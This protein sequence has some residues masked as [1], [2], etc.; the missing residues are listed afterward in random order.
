MDRERIDHVLNLNL[1]RTNDGCGEG[2]ELLQRFAIFGQ[3][4]SRA[5]A[6]EASLR[7]HF[8][9][10]GV[11]KK[12]TAISGLISP[13]SRRDTNARNR[14]S[15]GRKTLCMLPASESSSARIADPAF[16]KT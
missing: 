15:G 13:F 9:I 3:T 1:W 11:T 16:R 6:A 12:A 4:S 8:T 7:N 10:C 14:T 5:G 2:R